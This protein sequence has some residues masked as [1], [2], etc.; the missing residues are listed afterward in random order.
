VKDSRSGGSLAFVS[1]AL[2]PP[3]DEGTRRLAR[4]I[5]THASAAGV[6][7]VAISDRD[8]VLVRKLLLGA[9]LMRDVRKSGATTVVYLP[10][11]SASLGGLFRSGVLRNWARVRVVM[12]ATGPS[13]RGLLREVLARTLGPDLVLTPSASMLRDLRRLGLPAAFIPMGVDLGRFLPVDGETKQ[14]L[15][16]KFGLP[17]DGPIVLHVGHLRALRNFAWFMKAHQAVGATAVVVGGTTY[18]ADPGVSGQLTETG[19]H[20]IDRYLSNIQEVYQLADVYVFPVMD[21]RAAIGVPLSVLEGMACNLPVVTTPFDGLPKMFAEGD[22]L[23][24]AGD[25]GSF[26]TA[27]QTALTLPPDAV[28]TREK[29]LPYSWSNVVRM[30]L[31]SAQDC[32][33]GVPLASH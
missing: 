25:D 16:R 6:R 13:L 21:K 3:D 8:P 4:M 27:L 17:Q 31:R 28:R 24:Y 20:V 1:N 15:R 10:T 14:R 23:F 22:G 26:V 11:G 29:V 32:G 18:G 33:K 9:R 7:V 2:D 30:I 5:A 12:I 19:V